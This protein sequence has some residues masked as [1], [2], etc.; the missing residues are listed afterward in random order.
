M[1]FP[2]KDKRT[3]PLVVKLPNPQDPKKF[4]LYKELKKSAVE[5]ETSLHDFILYCLSKG[6]EQYKKEHKSKEKP[7]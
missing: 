6:L 5:E 4:N 7:A 2:K 3:S 1:S